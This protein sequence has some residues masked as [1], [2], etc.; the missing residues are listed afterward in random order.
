MDELPTGT[1]SSPDASARDALTSFLDPAE[2][3][4]IEMQQ[5][6]WT[7]ALVASDRCRIGSLG[8]SAL[9]LERPWR[10]RIRAIVAV[11]TGAQ[12]AISAPVSRLR[13]NRS[14]ACSHHPLVL[15][16]IR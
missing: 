16:G 12:R 6:T 8:S 9:S 4:D 2:L 5:R 13:R 7:P 11:L 1:S 10:V 14:I 15:R 3:L